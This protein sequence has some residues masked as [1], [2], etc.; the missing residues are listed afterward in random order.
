MFHM[1]MDQVSKLFSSTAYGVAATIFYKRS[2]RKQEIPVVL[3]LVLSGVL[4][5]IIRMQIIPDMTV[6]VGEAAAIDLNFK[7]LFGWSS[8]I[9]VMIW[10]LYLCYHHNQLFRKTIV[11]VAYLFAILDVRGGLVVRFWASTSQSPPEAFA[12]TWNVYRVCISA[13]TQFIRNP[14]WL[15]VQLRKT[16]K[17]YGL[18][19]IL[20]LMY[21]M[22]AAVTVDKNVFVVLM[23]VAAMVLA[24]VAGIIIRPDNAVILDA[25][26][27]TTT[28]TERRWYH[29]RMLGVSLFLFGVIT[30]MEF[31]Q[32]KLCLLNKDCV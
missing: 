7:F 5:D 11:F 29:G 27:I 19:Y 10:T 28:H 31:S 23:S 32:I 17:K 13:G 8:V 4:T 16:R 2:F 25:V 24:S 1:T 18:L 26:G 9:M 3:S 12:P 15:K 14:I 30:V 20:S 6:G 21:Y 22:I